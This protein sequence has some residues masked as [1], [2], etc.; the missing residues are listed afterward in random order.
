[1]I[2]VAI[3]GRE[4]LKLEHL[5]LDYNGTLARDGYLLPGVAEALGRLA[6]DLEI[7][8]LTADTFGLAAQGCEE[9]PV[10]LTVLPAQ[11]QA[12]G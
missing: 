7:H 11:G 12:S 9:L 10:K 8:V 3:P 5:V 4:T 1:M 6:R 2:V